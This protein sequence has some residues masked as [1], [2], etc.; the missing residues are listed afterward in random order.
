M[1]IFTISL[2]KALFRQIDGIMMKNP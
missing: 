1:F 2:L